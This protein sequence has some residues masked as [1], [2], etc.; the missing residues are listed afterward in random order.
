MVLSF[1]SLQAAFLLA[2]LPTK[3]VPHHTLPSSS[4]P[5]P[6]HQPKHAFQGISAFVYDVR[7]QQFLSS[8]DAEAMGEPCV[9]S[10]RA[11]Q[12]FPKG[13]VAQG[14]LRNVSKK[15]RYEVH[16][17][18]VLFFFVGGGILPCYFSWQLHASLKG[19]E[20]A[21]AAEKI[22]KEAG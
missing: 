11:E 18:C 10:A 14:G 2:L 6:V 8:H 17:H 12:T 19:R 22:H 16:G 15:R 13:V 3:R 1:P 5:S 21:G 20:G 4:R 7:W 9:H